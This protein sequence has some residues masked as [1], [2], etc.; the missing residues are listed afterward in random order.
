MRCNV[1][2]RLSCGLILLLALTWPKIYA[3]QSSSPGLHSRTSEGE[4]NEQPEDNSS[5]RQVST[6]P[7]DVSGSYHFAHY[8]DS[9]EIDIDRNHRTGHVELSGYISQLGDA[10]T[11]K[12]TPLTFFFNKT[13]IDGS[14]ISFETRI[15]HGIWYSFRGTIFR[16][17]AAEREQDG[18]YV[19]HG[20]LQEHH[21]QSV[22]EKSADE[23]I[24][25]RTVNF[26]SMGR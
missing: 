15:V 20:V 24:E 3:Q 26:K 19:L 11:D 18:Y 21:P 8:N 17:Q 14:Q 6:L 25:R 9:I 22:D 2:C 13:S 23:T 16:G 10:N 1:S 4:N 7:D 12:N 5:A